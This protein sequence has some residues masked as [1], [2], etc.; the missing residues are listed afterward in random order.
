[1]WSCILTFIN[2]TEAE[3][4]GRFPWNYFPD[5]REESPVAG[6]FAYNF[7]HFLAASNVNWILSSRVAIFV[8]TK[9]NPAHDEMQNRWGKESQSPEYWCIGSCLSIHWSL[10]LWNQGN[11]LQIWL[12]YHGQLLLHVVKCSP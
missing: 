12:R 6:K 3:F 2:K 4:V 11:I 10:V 1:M 8:I 5:K 9:T 7:T